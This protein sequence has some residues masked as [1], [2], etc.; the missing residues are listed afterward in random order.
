LAEF[1]GFEIRKKQAE[2]E[3]LDAFTPPIDSDGATI[4]A[5]G[6]A[7]GTYVDLEGSAKSEAELVTKYREMALHPE[8]ESAVDDIVNEAITVEE[9][10]D[11]VR[12]DLD[13]VELPPRAKKIVEQEFN[14]IKKLLD[15]ERQ[16]YDLFKRWYV[17]GRIYFQAVI[18]R[19]D[20]AAGIRELRYIDP[21]KI[22]KIR[23]VKKKKLN[24]KVSSA[25][26]GNV[27]VQQT[28][29]EYYI[30]SDKGF[31]SG[32][33]DVSSTQGLKIAKDSIV[34]VTS[35]LMDKGNTLVLSYLHKAIR[36]L[37][38][39]RT[40]EDATVIYR[41]S[42]A[43]ERRI[44]YIDVGNLPKMKAEQ[45]LRDMMVRHKNRIVYDSNTGEIRDDR[46]FMTM[47]EDYWLPRR[48]GNRGTEIQTLPGGQLVGE[49]NDVQY[50]QQKLLQSLNV[51]NA[52]LQPDYTY[53]PGR[54]TEISRDEIKFAKFIDRLR[55]RFNNLFLSCLEKQLILKGITTKEEWDQ[56][57][58][59]IDFNYTRDNYFAELKDMEIFAQRLNVLQQADAYVGKY[60]SSGWVKRNVLRQTDEQIEELEAEMQG[61][62]EQM[63]QAAA[64]ADQQQPPQE[65]PQTQTQ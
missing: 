37:N 46:K 24:T 8:V 29:A 6:G 25:Q 20:L 61:D 60:F 64:P 13:K 50:F 7:Y 51:P 55:T 18:D 3:K 48:E 36:P 47:L 40:L 41:V 34:H 57:A 4:V 56:F 53:N 27:T 45:Y 26:I 49:L 16:A 38:Q 2:P 44:F 32:M 17:D 58:I 54:S 11:V 52:R 31:K 5:A 1:F 62:L 28:E 19:N 42:R 43:P 39:L 59:D 33:N 22:R 63:T 15:F 12:I 21:R 30:Y 9:N 14:E 23:E 10:T 65:F 35:G